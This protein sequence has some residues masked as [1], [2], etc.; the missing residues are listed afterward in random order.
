MSLS[1]ELPIYKDTYK[2]ILLIYKR[3][4][5]FSRE[6]KYTLGQ[7]MKWI[8]L[9]LFVQYIGQI[10]IQINANI[11]KNFWITLKS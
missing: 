6:Y 10:V 11:S 9:S 7:D 8:V 4:K 3:T 1:Q 2:L 5:E